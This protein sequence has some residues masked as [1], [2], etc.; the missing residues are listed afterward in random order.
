MAAASAR[1]GREE[2]KK[3]RVR[4]KVNNGAAN[5]YR[6]R[7]QTQSIMRIT[8][9]SVVALRMA[10]SLCAQEREK[11]EREREVQQRESDLKCSSSDCAFLLL[12]LSP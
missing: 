12:R 8:P 5:V 11:N 2:E 9:T 1:E 7:P 10:L 3:R 4:G 6:Q